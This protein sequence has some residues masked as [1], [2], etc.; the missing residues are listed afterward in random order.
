[1]AEAEPIEWEDYLRV[2]F[3]LPGPADRTRL[4]ALVGQRLPEAWWQL[5]VK[6]QGRIPEP[7]VVPASGGGRVTFGLLLYALDPAVMGRHASYSVAG[8]WAAWQGRLPAGLVPFSDDTG[9]NNL[10]FD[11]RGGGDPTV[12]FVDHETAER[13]DLLAVAPDFATLL[14]SLGP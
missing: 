13:G 1:M 7:D 12:V 6:H 11:F 4:E 3:P 2:P 10:A 14:A 9:G 8:T 5:V